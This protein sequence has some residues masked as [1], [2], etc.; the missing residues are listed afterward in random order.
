LSCYRK[1]KEVR[2]LTGERKGAKK[3][4]P[5][6]GEENQTLPKKSNTSWD[7][8]GTRLG[9]EN[10]FATSSWNGDRLKEE[11]KKKSVLKKR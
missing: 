2:R 10:L 3:C 6:T 4:C 1:Q 9:E 11:E 5:F 8:E 7:T